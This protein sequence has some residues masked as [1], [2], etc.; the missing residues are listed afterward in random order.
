MKN[1]KFNL[2]GAFAV[3]IA[4]FFAG[5]TEDLCKDVDCGTNGDCNEGTCVCSTGYEG[6]LCDAKVNAKFAGAYNLTETC[7]PSGA[8]G[9]YAVTV[10]ASSTT[11]TGL[12]FTGLWEEP[13]SVASAEVSTSSSAAFTIAKQSYSNGSFQIEAN[14]TLNTTTN[15]ITITYTMFDGTGATTLDN[16]TATMQL[17]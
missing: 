2:L 13:G 6:T 1:M 11:A 10:T 8:A 4:L 14:G 5:C 16:C 15:T 12:T 17:Q 7:N 3:A 9:P